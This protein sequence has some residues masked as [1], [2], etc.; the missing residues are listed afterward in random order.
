MKNLS[1]I[2]VPIVACFGSFTTDINGSFFHHPFASVQDRA[3]N[4]DGNHQ[5]AVRGKEDPFTISAKSFL[6]N[7]SV[8][9]QLTSY[10]KSIL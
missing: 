2:S 8:L 6:S 1:L 9:R 5:A 4:F 7:Y 10:E 3:I